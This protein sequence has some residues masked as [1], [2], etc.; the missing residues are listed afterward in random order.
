MRYPSHYRR[1]P[2]AGR[3]LGGSLGTMLGLLLVTLAVALGV[4]LRALLL[5]AAA[6]L[7]RLQR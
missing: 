6:A 1:L 5:F 2:D 3:D 4:T 7:R